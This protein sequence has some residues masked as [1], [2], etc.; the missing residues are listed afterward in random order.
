MGPQS[1]PLIRAER[2]IERSEVTEYVPYS[3]NSTRLVE[4][5]GRPRDND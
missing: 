1:D 4:L 5:P 2:D 3:T